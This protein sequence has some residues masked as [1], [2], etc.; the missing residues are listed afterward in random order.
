VLELVLKAQL[1]R[2]FQTCACEA[3]TRK[4]RRIVGARYSPNKHFHLFF[5]F[6]KKI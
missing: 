1:G 3:L 4:G 5:L 2:T 6:Y